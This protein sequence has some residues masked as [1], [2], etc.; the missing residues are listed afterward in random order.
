MLTWTYF[1]SEISAGKI[2]IMYAEG[3]PD[4]RRIKLAR[5]TPFS[6]SW[7]MPTVSSSSKTKAFEVEYTHIQSIDL[8]VHDERVD[9]AQSVGHN[10]IRSDMV[11]VQVGFGQKGSEAIEQ[12]LVVFFMAY[13]PGVEEHHTIHVPLE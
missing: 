2:N 5:P 10:D 8:V 4:I 7:S 9:K 1:L 12:W 3:I 13:K 11:K 6:E